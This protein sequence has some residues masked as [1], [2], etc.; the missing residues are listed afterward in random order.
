MNTV[1][2]ELQRRRYLAAIH[3]AAKSL[4]MP[5]DVYR[6]MIERVSMQCGPPQRSA[7]QCSPRQ[8]RAIKAE[9]RRLGGMGHT[10]RAWP[11]RPKGELSP[12]MGKIEALLADAGRPWAYG[13]AVAKRVCKVARIEWCDKDQLAKV[14]AAQQIDANRRSR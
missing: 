11:D 3:A 10:P 4:A 6:A 7:G 9:L 8:L 12:Q 2:R 1:D 14:I 5:D 13:H